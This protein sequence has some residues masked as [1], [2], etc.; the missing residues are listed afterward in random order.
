V[1]TDAGVARFEPRSQNVEFF[2]GGNRMKIH[3]VAIWALATFAVAPAIGQQIPDEPRAAPQAAEPADVSDADLDT[4][5]TIY[6]D[7][8]ATVAK[9]EG[10]MQSAK[11]EQQAQ[12][13]RTRMQS[14]SVAKVAQ[15][16]W[17]PDKF[18]SVTE[19]INRNPALAE[20]A[21]K[22]IDEKS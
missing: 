17:T 8:L 14:E 11:D 21:A 19:A 3:T 10:E 4:F 5:T 1:R 2:Q 20:K 16:G 6:V 13:I 15:R 7:L 18:N 22:L 12:E 9:F